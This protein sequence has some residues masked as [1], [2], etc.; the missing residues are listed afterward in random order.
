MTIT[1]T[2]E[3]DQYLQIAQTRAYYKGLREGVERFA[4]WRD[5]TQ[6]VGT[7]G[8]TLKNVLQDI[9]SFEA[10]DLARYSMLK[11]L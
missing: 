2:P 4:W 10:D 9:N 8:S 11:K 3:Q 5:G 7:T 1:F 6:Y